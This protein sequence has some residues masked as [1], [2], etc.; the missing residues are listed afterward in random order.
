MITKKLLVAYNEAKP[1]SGQGDFLAV[2][3]T[4][5][6]PMF[7]GLKSR[8]YYENGRMVFLGKGINEK[9]VFVRLVDTGRKIE[10][11]D[12]TLKKLGNYIQQLGGFKIGNIITVAPKNDEV[13]FELVKIAE[14]PKTEVKSR[15]P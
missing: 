12:E 7:F 14:M 8:R 3:F 15:L 10:N 5:T 11:V 2:V 9:D 1:T 13:G 6:K 4:D